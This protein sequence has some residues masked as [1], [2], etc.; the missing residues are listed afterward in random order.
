MCALKW[1]YD[2]DDVGLR[3]MAKRRGGIWVPGTGWTFSDSHKTQEF[4]STITKRHPDWPVIGDPDK[5]HL[6]MSKTRFSHFALAD[7]MEAIL[8]R[9]PMPPFS[10]VNVDQENIKSFKVLDKKKEFSLLIGHAD[11]I[12][13]VFESLISHYFSRY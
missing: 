4:L 8:V 5:P 12:A 3:S 7:S 6:E 10:F 9:L 13:T 11:S 2:S 1:L